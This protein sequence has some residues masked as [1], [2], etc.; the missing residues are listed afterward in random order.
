MDILLILFICSTATVMCLSRATLRQNV[1]QTK[2][3]ARIMARAFTHQ[4]NASPLRPR[5]VC[6][7]NG[8]KGDRHDRHRS[9]LDPP[10]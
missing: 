6:E 7:T 3:D 10:C 1:R 2:Q 5:G 9:A 8:R 4:T